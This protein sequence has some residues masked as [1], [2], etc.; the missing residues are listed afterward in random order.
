EAQRIKLARELSKVGTGDTLYVM[1]EPTTGLH[2]Q[3]VRM[4]VNVIQKLVEKG[5]TVMVIEHNL[6]LIKAA[7][8][9]I[10]MGPEGGRGGG[11]IIAQ[12]TP[13]EVAEVESSHTGKFLKEEF[14]RLQK[15]TV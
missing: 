10:D 3:D 8:W 7:D 11:E 13:E 5:N 4:L 14:E 1:D 9:L 6:D 12:G 2:F 15:V